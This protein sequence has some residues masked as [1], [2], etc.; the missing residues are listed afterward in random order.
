[1]AR[2][3]NFHV[4][5]GAIWGPTSWQRRGPSPS[6]GKFRIG[7]IGTV[8]PIS[9]VLPLVVLFITHIYDVATSVGR[10]ITTY[11][12]HSTLNAFITHWQITL[13]HPVYSAC[14]LLRPASCTDRSEI[15]TQVLVT[16]TVSRVLWN[17]QS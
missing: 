11:H 15:F 3:L 2:S 7:Y 8:F 12:Y 4:T 10:F 14:S 5:L 1:M 17:I 16:I 6:V 13:C 9:G